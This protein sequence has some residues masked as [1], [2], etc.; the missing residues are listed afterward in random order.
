MNGISL[1]SGQSGSIANGFLE[2]TP[3]HPSEPA[4]S[5]D[6]R[7]IASYFLALISYLCLYWRSV[8]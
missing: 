3:K 1:S 8:M 5:S 4:L 2:F 6:L 7:G